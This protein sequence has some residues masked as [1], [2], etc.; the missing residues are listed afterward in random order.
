LEL[1][2]FLT[3]KPGTREAVAPVNTFAESV[4]VDFHKSPGE[5][6]RNNRNPEEMSLAELKTYIAGATIIGSDGKPERM[7]GKR[8]ELDASRATLAEMQSQ[9]L[10]PT[11]IQAQQEE[12]AKQT[13]DLYKMQAKYHL[14]IAAPFSCIIFVLLAAPLGMNPLRAT[15]TMGFGLSFVMVFV[16]YLLTT[17]AVN[18]ASTGQL[19]IVPLAWMPN[20]VFALYGLYLN[21]QF[22]WS[23]GK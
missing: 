7:P 13:R 23:S 3:W 22:V 4:E 6:L 1:V 5:I 10:D 20:V 8:E 2:N 12:I 14:K 19:P 15:N 18:L 17:L 21:G 11:A 9:H 16:Y